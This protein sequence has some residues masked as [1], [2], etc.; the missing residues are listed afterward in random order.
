MRYLKTLF[1][2]KIIF[3]FSLMDLNG[4]AIFTLPDITASNGETFC[5]DVTAEN[6]TEVLSM[7]FSI[8]WNPS[9]IEFSSLN[10]IAAQFGTANIT[11]NSTAG[12]LSFSWFSGNPTG[13]TLPANDVVFEICFTVVGASGG[14]T[15][16][17]FTNNPAVIEVIT[18]SSSP[19][20]IGLT[21]Q[22]GGVIVP[23]AGESLEFSIPNETYS[24]GVSFCLPVSAVNFIDLISIQFSINWD[25]TILQYDSITAIAIPEATVNDFGMPDP[26]GNIGFSWFDNTLAGVTLPDNTTVF[27]ICFTVIG[28]PNDITQIEFTDNPVPS[29][30]IQGVN[31][32]VGLNS[33]GGVITVLQSLFI[34]NA[35]IIGTSCND[36]EN[37]S[38]DITVAGGLLPYTFMWSNSATSEDLTNLEAGVY[39]LTILDSNNPPN[40]ITETYIVPGDFE[41]PIASAGSDTSLTCADP[42][43][44][45]DGTSSSTGTE[46]IYEW[47]TV[48]VGAIQNP[49][50]LTPSVNATG[51]YTLL[52]TNTVNGCSATD[53]LIVGGNAIPPVVDAGSGGEI[54]CL[55]SEVT[56]TGTVDPV[57]SNYTYQWTNT[58]TGTIVSNDISVM[59]NES[60]LY[61]FLATDASGCS[62]FDTVS[63]IANIAPPIANAGNNM[64]LN[65]QDVEVVL[66]GSSSSDG[67]NIIYEWTSSNSSFIQNHTSVNPTVSEVGTYQLE[68]TNTTTNCTSTTTVNVTENITPPTAVAGSGGAIDCMNSS[69]TLNGDGSSAGI[70]FTY[71]WETGDGNIASGDFTLMP[72]VDNEGTYILTVTDTTNHCTATDSLEVTINGV[73]PIADAGPDRIIN[74][75]IDTVQLD[76]SDS[77]LGTGYMYEWTTN[78]GNIVSGGDFVVPLVDAGGEY[79]LLVTDTIN[80]CSSSS[81]VTVI[82]DTIA[83]IAQTDPVGPLTCTDT[84]LTLTNQN[85][86]NGNG[87]TFQWTTTNGSIINATPFGDIIV[88]GAGEYTLVVTDNNNQCTDSDIINLEMDD[89]LPIA[90]AGTDIVLT[91]TDSTV[92]LDGAASSTGNDFTYNWTTIS[93][94]IVSGNETLFPEIDQDGI[95]H[96]EVVDTTNGC[97]MLDSVEVTKD[98]N[99]PIVNAGPNGILDCITPEIMLDGT[100]NSSSGPSFFIEWTTTSIGNIVSGENT[101]TP[102]VNAPG[103][104]T[105]TITNLNNQCSSN[106]VLIVSSNSLTPTAIAGADTAIVCDET[107]L[108][109]DGSNSSVGNEFEYLWTTNNGNIITDSTDISITIDAG[110]TYELL[111]TNTNN[112]CTF[113]DEVVVT[114]D[115][116]PAPVAD[117]QQNSNLNCYNPTVILDGSASM[118]S[119]TQTFEWIG[120]GNFVSDTNTLTPTIDAPGFYSLIV[121]DNVTGCTSQSSAFILIDSMT[122]MATA[123]VNG[124]LDCQNSLVSLDGTGSTT[125]Q[126][127]IYEW[128]TSNGSIDSDSSLIMIDASAGGDY[129]LMVADTI[130]GCSAMISVEV[131]I[132]TLQPIADAGGV[133]LQLPCGTPSILLDGSASSAGNGYEYLWTTSNGSIINGANGLMPEI[134]E[135]GIYTLTVTNTLNGCMA[136]S[137]IQVTEPD[138][139]IAVAEV[140]SQLDCSSN[141]VILNGDGSS[142]GANIAYLWTTTDGNIISDETILSIEVDAPGTYN[143]EVMN[144]I[145]GCTQTTSVEVV[146]SNAFPNADA[147]SDNM[148]CENSIPLTANLPAGTTGIWLTNGSAMF[149]D[150]SDPNSMVN[151]LVEGTNVFSW[152]LSAPGCPEYSVDSVII[153]LQNT[154]EASDDF[155]SI[156]QNSGVYEFNSLINDNGTNAT[157]QAISGVA[158]GTL[159]DLGNGGFSY[160]PNE[161]F[162]GVEM[163]DYELCSDNCPDAC[164]V[165]TV[166]IT[167]E[168]I[169]PIDPDSVMVEYNAITPNGDGL[170]DVFIFDFLETNLEQFPDNELVVFNRWGDIVYE[171]K[172]YNNDWGGTNQKG[173]DLPQGTYYYIL[174]LDI[175]ERIILK[176]DVTI[177]K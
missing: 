138:A 136:T 97:I 103:P 3:L 10:N 44:I 31:T 143:L 101:L 148:V 4:Q 58:T 19:N 11:P 131:L 60:G 54:T 8:N 89:D 111:V 34:P 57:A 174:R 40:S 41:E 137:Q 175:T 48:G 109:L 129:Q 116:S 87:I 35:D 66:D 70:N 27:E 15:D 96:L 108:V 147:G 123:T 141:S 170:N 37:G 121:T 122:P 176:G 124:S 5:I 68:V 135:I 24:S 13:A 146:F 94:N 17:S 112:G 26:A 20:N 126:F 67:V 154:P 1:F 127:I 140:N 164:D 95:Y 63:V 81:T 9:V 165:A 64:E 59:A 177:L 139:V 43:L 93:G 30:V 92:N 113:S 22:G 50:T 75:Q 51:L 110:G 105:L 159:T 33:S 118:I 74:C 130:N 168:E 160:S 23:T 107:M 142:Q 99:F 100:G 83:P 45:L 72:V 144:S 133:M 73:L 169:P 79:T 145:S 62:A 152:T 69:V 82:L 25:P 39:T 29:E 65:C 132:D 49:T 134:G 102:T 98:L 106:D 120:N 77:S 28:D 84:E 156:S 85:S 158:N 167:I 61:E 42:V 18:A 155:Y 36:S 171:A 12:T 163:F 88:N 91:C 47:T 46:F 6:L 157:L 151:N 117:V 162:I 71:E 80:F 21:V 2:I 52:V 55:I 119:P 115:T 125:G 172:P 32:D 149:A 14:A 173:T 166:S 104:Y 38:I 90:N 153:M 114:Q 56:L 150:P 16:I 7:Q 161:D 76:G 78:E 86:S 128:M 53:N